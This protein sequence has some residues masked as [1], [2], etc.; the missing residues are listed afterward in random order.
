M[1]LIGFKSKYVEKEKDR[2]FRFFFVESPGI[3]VRIRNDEDVNAKHHSLFGKKTKA[4]KKFTVEANTN[5]MEFF[6]AIW[7]K[8]SNFKKDRM[9]QF[10]QCVIDVYKKKC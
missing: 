4:D 2:M 1:V 10:R 8:Y 3:S 9:F 5:R 7:S 6:T